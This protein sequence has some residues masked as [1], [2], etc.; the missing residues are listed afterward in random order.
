MP[1]V[2]MEPGQLPQG[3]TSHQVD[4]V[5]N[6]LD[7]CIT[8]QLLPVMKALLN[9]NT[10]RTYNREMRLQSLC[11]EMYRKGFPVD[12]MAVLELLRDLEREA[13][14][15]KNALHLFCAAVWGPLLNPNSWQQVEGFFYEFLQLPPIWKYDH[16]TKVRKRG[17]DRDSLEKLRDNYPSSMPFVNAILAYREATK[18]AGVFKKGLEPVTKRLRC[19]FSPSGTDTGRLSSQSNP[20]NRGTNAQNLNDRVR[21]VVKAPDG[22]IF[23]YPDLKTAESFATGFCSRSPAYIAACARDLHTTV[24]RMVWPHLPWTGDD[25]KD[26]V[27][28]EKPFYRF[29][30]YRD[31]SKRGGHASNYYGQPPTIAKHLKVDKRF[32]EEFQGGYFAAFP[33]IPEWHIEQIARIQRDGKLVTIM[34][35]ERHFWGRPDDPATHRAGIAFEPQ[36]IVA[37]VMNEGLMQV[38]DWLIRE[39]DYARIMAHADAGLLAQIHDAG[40]FLIPLDGAEQILPEILTRMVHPVDWGEQGVMTIPGE[41]SIGLNWGKAKGDKNPAGLKTWNPG[42]AIHLAA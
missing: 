31:M 6:C 13:T 4:Q 19:G 25:D 22:F 33:E 27:I 40:L 42:E 34:G 9:D 38:Q 5:Y 3:L 11:L 39:C 30:S 7:S 10:S 2:I 29:F 1:P 24:A 8:A 18:L 35:R 16:K 14:K 36:S 41:M 21:R 17:T 15:A 20:F 28:A 32:I 12:E 23:A 37:D 26:K